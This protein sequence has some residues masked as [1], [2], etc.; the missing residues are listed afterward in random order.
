MDGWKQMIKFQLIALMGLLSAASAMAEVVH[1]T[2]KF[3]PDPSRPHV[4]VFENTTPNSGY[5]GI[6]P[7][8]CNSPNYKIFSVGTNIEFNSVRPIPA[9]HT[10]PRAGATF[11]VPANWKIVPVK[12]ELGRDASAV[13][14]RVAGFGGTYKLSKRVQELIGEEIPLYPALNKL[15]EFGDWGIAPTGCNETAGGAHVTDTEHDFFWL[16]PVERYCSN[17]ARFEVPQFAYRD[18]SF[19]YQIK[20]PNPLKMAPG[21][22]TGSAVYTVGPHLDFDFGDNMQPTDSIIQIDFTLTVDH[23]FNIEIPPGGHKVVLLP[24][25]GWQAWLNHGRKPTR[26]FRDQ[27][28]NVWTSTP[29]KMKLECSEPLGDTCALQ[30]GKGDTVPLNI[31]VSLPHG[32]V[33]ASGSSVTRRP[34]LLSGS[35]T[36]RFEPNIYVDRKPGTLHFEVTK[37]G[38]AQMLKFPGHSYSGEVTVIWD[39]E[40]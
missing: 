18:F 40:V 23:V 13:E 8:T 31:N 15:W 25:G 5:C 7:Q 39:S 16:S 37:E 34:L 19:A 1:I 30:D 35:G 21:I 4:N 9:K 29:F 22:Y 2:A 10:N 20:T 28:F 36:E 6:Y 32:L 27:T 33:D 11:K 17:Q 26:L 3:A 24:E 38:V 12:D 14:L